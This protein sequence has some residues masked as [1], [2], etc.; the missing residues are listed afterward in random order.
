MLAFTLQD[1]LPE[2]NNSLSAY[3]SNILGALTA[4]TT[5]LQ[6]NDPTEKLRVIDIPIDL[7]ENH[8]VLG[9]PVKEKNRRLKTEE[10]LVAQKDLDWVKENVKKKVLDRIFKTI[11]LFSLFNIFLTSCKP[12]IKPNESL[13]WA[14]NAKG[15]FLIDSVGNEK[16]GPYD[17]VQADNF[18]RYGADDSLFYIPNHYASIIKLYKSMKIEPFY[19]LCGAGVWSDCSEIDDNKDK[20][21]YNWSYLVMNVEKNM[22]NQNVIKKGIVNHKGQ[23]VIEPIQSLKEPST[24]FWHLNRIIDI[25]AGVTYDTFGNVLSVQY[26]PAYILRN[27]ND[28]YRF[29]ISTKNQKNKVTGYWY[30]G[31]GCIETQDTAVSPLLPIEAYYIDKVLK[32]LSGRKLRKQTSIPPFAIKCLNNYYGVANQ[33]S[34]LTCSCKYSMLHKL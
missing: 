16:M 2:N 18:Y 17:F 25:G 29:C 31:Y 14:K 19:G 10:F 24:A 21:C 7:P 20:L 22:F 4:N 12:N 32:D 5:N 26:D 28:N 3:L 6:Y 1:G 30:D 27:P 8:S 13:F 23:I 11:I 9:L 15:W 34:T 33:D